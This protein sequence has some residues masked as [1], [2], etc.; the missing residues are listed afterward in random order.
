MLHLKFFFRFSLVVLAGATALRGQE[1]STMAIQRV[2][3]SGRSFLIELVRD[4][5]APMDARQN[6]IHRLRQL[7]AEPEAAKLSAAEFYEP[8]LAALRSTGAE[9]QPLRLT[10]CEALGAF[11][12]EKG[13]P[14]PGT[15]GGVLKTRAETTAL[16]TA[17][18]RALGQMAGNPGAASAPLIDALEVELRGGPDAGNIGL[19]RTM[20]EALG[21]LRAEN[22]RTVLLNVLESNFPQDVKSAARR[23]L[24]NLP[25]AKK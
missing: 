22:G 20:V 5:T 18:A 7:A 23:S 21:R 9:N 13:G 3:L 11:G 25:A 17:A 12:K 8:I 1:T 19:V 4:P 15:L 14:I 24:E 10:A 16:R 6:A 2:P